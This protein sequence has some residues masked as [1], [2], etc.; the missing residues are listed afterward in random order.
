MS[1]KMFISLN[2]ILAFSNFSHCLN[3]MM[4]NFPMFSLSTNKLN[5]DSFAVLSFILH[6]NCLTSIVY[7]VLRSD[8]LLFYSATFSQYQPNFLPYFHPVQSHPHTDSLICLSCIE[9][10]CVLTQIL[11]SVF[12]CNLSQFASKFSWSVSQLYCI[13]MVT[14]VDELYDN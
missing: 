7:H 12:Y 11:P 1:L 3:Q 2:L 8:V 5:I 4:S 14:L 13:G 10:W 9:Q 6:L